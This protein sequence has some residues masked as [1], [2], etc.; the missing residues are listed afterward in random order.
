MRK[1]LL[2]VATLMIA[3]LGLAGCYD[4]GHPGHDSDYHHHHHHDGDGY[5]H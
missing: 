4:H 1:H 2:L 3:G 5:G